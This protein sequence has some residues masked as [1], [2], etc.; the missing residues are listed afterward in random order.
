MSAGNDWIRRVLTGHDAEA[1]DTEAEEEPAPPSFDGGP[2]TSVPP[3]PPTMSS[4]IRRARWG[5]DP[6]ANRPDDAA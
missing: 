2:R 3:A 5:Y 6:Y 4:L 1:T